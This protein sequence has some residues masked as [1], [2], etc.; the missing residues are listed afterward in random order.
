[1]QCRNLAFCLKQIPYTERSLRKLIDNVSCY[2]DKLIDNDI[3][4]AFVS[5]CIQTAKGA[6]S[7]LKVGFAVQ[8]LRSKVHCYQ[9][10]IDLYV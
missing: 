8:D 6:K 4:D 9:Y 5:I 7:E 10:Y 1:M 3:Y 2:A